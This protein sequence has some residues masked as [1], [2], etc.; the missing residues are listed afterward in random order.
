M[1][2]TAYNLLLTLSLG[3]IS[4]RMTRSISRLEFSLDMIS[5]RS[6]AGLALLSQTLS[7]FYIIFVLYIYICP[8]P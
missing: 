5:P 6:H 8:Y 2:Y 1:S 3:R 4:R 7:V